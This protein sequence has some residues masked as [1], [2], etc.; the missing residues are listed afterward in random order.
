MNDLE[1]KM[2]RKTTFPPHFPKERL[3]YTVNCALLNASELT[4]NENKKKKI[5][6][7][8]LNYGSRV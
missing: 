7:K 1:Y 4:K 5:N 6:V 8:T 3:K 2:S